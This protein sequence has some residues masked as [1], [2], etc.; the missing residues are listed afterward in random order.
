MQTSRKSDAIMQQE[1][2][3]DKLNKAVSMPDRKKMKEAIALLLQQAYAENLA[4]MCVV[5]P[6]PE[7]Q[8]PCQQTCL[9]VGSRRYFILFT[10]A[11]LFRSFALLQTDL[12]LS[13]LRCRDVLDNV[14]NLDDVHGLAF[15]PYFSYTDLNAGIL[16]R[17]TDLP[18]GAQQEKVSPAEAS[19]SHSQ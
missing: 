19:D 18:F 15:N 9:H 11:K 8:N 16:I 3:W 6:D 17:K 2:L 7:D 4:L 5:E 10:D 12:R 1:E 13:G 14:F